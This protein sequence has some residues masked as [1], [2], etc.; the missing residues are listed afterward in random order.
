MKYRVKGK[1]VESFYKGNWVVAYYCSSAERAKKC[2][3]ECRKRHSEWKK[4]SSTDRI[5][6]IL[7]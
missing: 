6:S 1:T 5:K 3:I 2:V 7:R 4:M